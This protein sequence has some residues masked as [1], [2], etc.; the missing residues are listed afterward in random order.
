MDWRL[1]ELAALKNTVATLKDQVY[2]LESRLNE[3][4]TVK[5]PWNLKIEDQI[6]EFWPEADNIDIEESEL[7]FSGR[8]PCPK[9]WDE[10]KEEFIG[11][12]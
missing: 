5:S 2:E 11:S 6:A 7:T 4:I 3:H 8:F 9:W 1:E 10:E 12:A